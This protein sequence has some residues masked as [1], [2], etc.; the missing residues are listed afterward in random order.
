MPVA[1]HFFEYIHRDALEPTVQP[2]YFSYDERNE[3]KGVL[4]RGGP[5][6]MNVCS[7]AESNSYHW[8][9]EY[10]KKLELTSRAFSFNLS[11]SVPRC[12][13]T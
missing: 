2:G 7:G 5:S 12:R 6:Y 1:H 13:L 11:V 9:D 4:D 10:S 3:H 8:G